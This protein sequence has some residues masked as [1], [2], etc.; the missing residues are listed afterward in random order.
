M[1]TLNIRSIYTFIS[2]LTVNL[3]FLIKISQPL[4]ER[5]LYWKRNLESSNQ[6]T[7]APFLIISSHPFCKVCLYYGYL[8]T[9]IEQL[10]G[11]FK[12]LYFPRD[13]QLLVV[14]SDVPKH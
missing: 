14:V 5:F 9:F 10:K 7:F 2:T 12:P 13:T 6:P 8:Y 3:L 11:T 4:L 1:F